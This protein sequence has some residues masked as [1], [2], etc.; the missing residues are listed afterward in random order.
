MPFAIS[1]CTYSLC[2]TASKY[3]VSEHVIRIVPNP[4]KIETEYLL[5]VLQSEY[6]QKLI[7]KG[8]Y[9][10]VIDEI[11]PAHLGEIDIPIPKSKK[12]Y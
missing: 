4:D 3:A 7:A 8:I 1:F 5:A 11:N 6:V 10:S 2:K 12:N 9:G